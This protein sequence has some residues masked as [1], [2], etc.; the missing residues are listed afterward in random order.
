MASSS[1]HAL[2]GGSVRTATLLGL[3]IILLCVLAPAPAVAVDG[4]N[5]TAGFVQVD[6]PEGNFVVQ[7][8]Y[9]VPENQRY[10]YDV[11]TGVRT[12]WVYADDKP[13]TTVTL[14]NPRAEVRLSG[15]DY[16]SG[17]WQFEGYGYV[18]SGTSGTGA[19]VEDGIY[20]RWFRLNVVHDVG[21]STVAVYVDGAPKLA[22]NVTPSASHYFKFGVYVQHH[23]VSPR[24][25]SRW[26][27]VA[28][29]TKPY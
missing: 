6:L 10:S 2:A 20:D 27:N 9:D 5:L 29:Y 17:I 22:A 4:C 1:L 21:A 19:A 11:A 7:S 8:P 14:T 16:S 12:F 26:R 24:V 15:H 3:V 13:F 28:V 23:D 18:P 25:E